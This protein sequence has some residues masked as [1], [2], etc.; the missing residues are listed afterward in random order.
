M[1]PHC[2]TYRHFVKPF[3]V[4]RRDPR[5][6]PL[7]QSVGMSNLVEIGRRVR[8][9][10]K[11]SKLTQVEA[12]EAI[13]L[14]RS[15][16]TEIELGTCRGGIEAMT[17]IADYFKVPFDWLLCRKVP[18]GGPL[19]GE[20]LEDPDELALVHFWRSLSMEDRAAIPRLLKIPRAS[21]TA[22]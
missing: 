4:A 15:Y 6:W 10:R 16:L 2:R 12:A 13:G 18:P 8:R 21:R 7:R 19:V 5:L 20:F 14:A 17:A 1:P 3:L 9:L 22:S 11:A